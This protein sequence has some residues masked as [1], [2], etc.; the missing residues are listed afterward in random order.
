MVCHDCRWLAFLLRAKTWSPQP[1]L[2]LQSSAWAGPL[3]GREGTPEDADGDGDED[4]DGDGS[5]DDADDD[6]V[7]ADGDDADDDD[8]PMPPFT[9]YSGAGG[10]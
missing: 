8:V 6:D 1:A 2:R 10:L 4:D 7:D 5:E 9:E 3:A